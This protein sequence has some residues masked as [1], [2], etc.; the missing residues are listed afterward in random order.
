[1]DAL[2]KSLAIVMAVAAV[3]CIVP[4]LS[5]TADAAG[6]MDG[7]MLYEVNPWNNHEGVSVFN[8]GDSAVDLTDYYISDNPK[9]DSREGY[10]FF[11]ES[12]IVEPDTF[13]VIASESGDD[14]NF[15]SRDGVSVYYIGN[16]GI[17]TSGSFNLANDGDDIYLFKDGE[18]IDAVCYG[19]TVIEDSALWAS[20]VS[21]DDRKDVFFHRIGT[22]DSDSEDDWVDYIPGWTNNEFDPNQ[23][24][25][26]NVAPFLFPDHGGIPVYEALDS[27]TKSVYIEIYMITEPNV[28]ALLTDLVHRGVQV[29]V[30]L[31]GEVLSNNYDPVEDMESYIQYFVDEGGEVRLIGVG[32]EGVVDRFSYVHSKYAVIDG[33][34]VVVTSENWT[35]SNLNGSIDDDPYSGNDGNRGWGAVIE[36]KEY[37]EYMTAVFN[38][39]FSMAYGDV[40]E[41][42]DVHND[43]VAVKSMTY[44][45]PDS[46]SLDSYSAYVTPVLSNDNSY[47]AVQYYI[48]NSEF[49][50]YAE[51]QSLGVEFRDMSPSSPVT[52]INERAKDG[53]DC[54]IILDDTNE[55]NDDQVDVI[56]KSSLVPAALMTG[57]TLHNKG[58][59][60]DD[61]VWVSSV[62]WTTESFNNNREVCAVIES[63]EIADFF[64]EHILKDFNEFYLADGK[65]RID[66]SEIQE[67][68]TAGEEITLT[69]SVKPEGEY[70]YLWDL[71]DGSDVIE[72]DIP[73]ISCKPMFSGDA[74]TYVLTV[75]VTDLDG[76][77]LNSVTRDYTIVAEESGDVG[78]IGELISDNLYILAPLIVIILGAIA[79]VS[80]SGSKKR[81]TKKRK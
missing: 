50:V 43:A 61:Y 29:S 1:M 37:A 77:V 33:T 2:G 47:E 19:N 28:Y 31:E 48:Q 12:I 3:I 34:T 11:N 7:L 46:I 54:F 63:S 15:I 20:Y 6:E 68:Y 79:A 52:M 42:E 25:L 35:P 38:N 66:I 57:T 73:R 14:C 70:K 60:C 4:V 65:P 78:D 45:E 81:S 32:D 44:E 49:R 76:Q 40:K 67:T 69:V 16:N 13:V 39:D 18:I 23:K 8:Y 36:S 9:L 64:A 58:L 56:N 41:F 72:S 62:N 30:L 59:I 53:V 27:A 80:R 10:I 5:D 55:N 22:Y 74:S 24:F 17:D 26:S 71:G 21:V 75:T 51:Q